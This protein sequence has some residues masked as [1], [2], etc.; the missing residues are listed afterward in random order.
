MHV[1]RYLDRRSVNTSESPVERDRVW[2]REAE[3]AAAF[4]TEH[5]RLPLQGT[6]L[7]GWLTAQRRAGREGTLVPWRRAWLNTSLPGWESR[8]VEPDPM[9]KVGRDAETARRSAVRRKFGERWAANLDQAVSF[10]DQHGYLPPG[11]ISVGRWLGAQRSLARKTEPG[12]TLLPSRRALLDER[13]PGWI[14]PSRG[15]S[16]GRGPA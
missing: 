15:R 5:G 16:R 4:L 6:P 14:S 10:Y 9:T 11:S 2:R 1:W 8:Q 3:Q 7:G 12:P 13:L